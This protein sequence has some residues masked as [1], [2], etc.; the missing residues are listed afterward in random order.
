MTTLSAEGLFAQATVAHKAGRSKDAEALY[1]ALIDQ[2]PNHAGAYHNLGVILAQHGQIA[3]ALP[4]L[5]R[6]LHIA[7][8]NGVFAASCARALL[9]SGRP[10]E[11]LPILEK[12]KRWGGSTPALEQLL[13]RA[14]AQ[15]ELGAGKVDGLYAQAVEH[16]QARRPHQAEALYRKVVELRP[17]HANA[18]DNLGNLLGAQGRFDE[19]IAVYRQALNRA[20]GNAE[21]LDNLGYALT[22]SGKIEEAIA[23]YRQAVAA[24]P[25]FAAAHFHLGS[26]L[27]EYG[28]VGEGFAH[29]LRRAELVYAGG[30]VPYDG[31]PPPH[32]IKHDSEQREYLESLGKIPPNAPMLPELFYLEEGGRL[33]GPAVNKANATAQMMETWRSSWP[34]H[35]VL[36]NFLMPPALEKLRRYCAGS[37]VWRRNYNAGY[38]G[39]SPED[40]FS[41]PLLAQIVEETHAVF[42]EILGAHLFQYLGAFKYDSELST[43]TNIHADNSAVNV[44]FYIAPDEANL[45]AE[46]GGMDIWD[47]VVPVGEDMKT[48]NGNEALAR[49]FLKQSNARKSVIPHRANR[50]VIFRSEHFHK[51]GDCTFAEGYLNK[52]INVSLL[53]GRRGA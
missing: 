42:H 9:A 43:G 53:F 30:K 24:A 28:H 8:V 10:D 49:E 35:V 41:C 5:E 47:V 26:V 3:E 12:A 52:R 18:W 39:A 34:Q 2:E 6:A 22:A 40:G 48:Y 27:S 20:P 23:A 13:N 11:A 17:G 14:R 36:D 46:S 7:P 32:R 29:F 44:N 21:M 38:I 1:R 33:P 51:T 31:K 25:D 37:T 4:L 19:A 50:A 45:D 16:H 15:A